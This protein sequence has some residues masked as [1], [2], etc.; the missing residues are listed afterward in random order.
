MSEKPT[1]T[2]QHDATINEK[3]R[4]L[5]EIIATLEDGDIS[6][7]KAKNLHSEGQELLKALQNDLELGEGEIIELD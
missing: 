7:E 6:L 5:E 3:T 1:P 2:T 4:R